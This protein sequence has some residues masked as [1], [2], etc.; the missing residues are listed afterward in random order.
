MFIN[1]TLV[2]FYFLEGEGTLGNMGQ[3]LVMDFHY[4][5][6]LTKEKKS[7]LNLLLHSGAQ[8]NVQNIVGA[9]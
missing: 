7:C 2:V 3:S 8:H 5:S 4:F 6:L 9:Q 1:V